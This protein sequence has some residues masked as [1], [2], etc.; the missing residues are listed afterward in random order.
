MYVS[1]AGYDLPILCRSESHATKYFLGLRCFF[2]N[3]A[4][5]LVGA[6]HCLSKLTGG[7]GDALAKG[8]V[9]YPEKSPSRD[10][11]AD[12]SGVSYGCLL[13]GR[14]C[15]PSCPRLRPGKRRMRGHGVQ[16]NTWLGTL[17][18][19]QVGG[20]DLRG[21]DALLLQH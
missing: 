10:G 5:I 4:S 17:V 14:S 7:P 19:G 1:F 15:L 18:E 16:G 13:D 11:I 3:L 8:E 9:S 20:H 12:L 21:E 6:A 2:R